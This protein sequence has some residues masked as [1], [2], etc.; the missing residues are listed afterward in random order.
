MSCNYTYIKHPYRWL[1]YNLYSVVVISLLISCVYMYMHGRI[2]DRPSCCVPCAKQ[3]YHFV[4]TNDNVLQFAYRWSVFFHEQNLLWKVMFANEM[5]AFAMWYHKTYY[6]DQSLK[7]PHYTVLMC[8]IIQLGL[9]CHWPQ[10]HYI[11][12]SINLKHNFVSFFPHQIRVGLIIC[13]PVK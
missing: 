13:V 2:F 10:G 7:R 12:C 4:Y 6:S 1:D 11:T 8:T 9:I 3:L 5:F